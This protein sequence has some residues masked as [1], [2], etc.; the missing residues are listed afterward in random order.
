M[1]TFKVFLTGV[2]ISL[3]ALHFMSFASGEDSETFELPVESHAREI[4]FQA[5]NFSNPSSCLSAGDLAR[6][7]EKHRVDVSSFPEN[8]AA[9]PNGYQQQLYRLFQRLEKLKLDDSI[10]EPNAIV[11]TLKDPLGFFES[12]YSTLRY[13]PSDRAYASFNPATRLMQLSDAFFQQ[14]QIVGIAILMHESAHSREED[15]GHAQCYQGQLMATYGGC[16][17]Q[18]SQKPEQSGAYG[19]EFWFSWV[20]SKYSNQLARDEKLYLRQKA[21]NLATHRFNHV[22][23]VVAFTDLIVGLDQHNQLNILDPLAKQWRPVRHPRISGISP[24]STISRIDYDARSHG[25][26]LIM[27]NGRL[28]QWD[29]IARDFVSQ[30]DLPFDELDQPLAHIRRVFDFNVGA[31][32]TVAFTRDGSLWR[33]TTDLENQG[34]K[35]FL[36]FVRPEGLLGDPLDV[37][38]LVGPKTAFLN[39][40]GQLQIF[41]QERSLPVDMVDWPQNPRG[42]FPSLNGSY[43]YVID[44]DTGRLLEGTLVQ[45][46]LGP[47]LELDRV[48]F[49]EDFLQVSESGRA[50]KYQEG[51]SKRVLLD[52]RGS[53]RVSRHRNVVRKIPLPEVYDLSVSGIEIKDVALVRAAQFQSSW[54]YD[55]NPLEKSSFERRC[56]LEASVKD[57]W[58]ERWMGVNAQNQ[59]VVDDRGQCLVLDQGIESLSSGIADI[60]LNPFGYPESLL[61]MKRVNEV[62]EEEFQPY[63]NW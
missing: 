37:I 36:P 6:E 15:R 29:S 26:N 10:P 58:L 54:D 4:W 17:M 28:I 16:D 22:F 60:K 59:W 52:E 43:M 62:A 34:A 18:L 21:L 57:P 40:L 41:E 42:I 38:S 50:K 12:S 46:T 32:R 1:H 35:V 9:C 2:L 8:S 31:P 49:K 53:L 27:Q 55:K 63:L 23:E 39:S 30:L 13:Y 45:R 25:L 5:K 20:Y 61:K 33:E 24:E 11:K 3:G 47:I 48:E 51:F 19:Y 14:P 7:L 44:S 56:S